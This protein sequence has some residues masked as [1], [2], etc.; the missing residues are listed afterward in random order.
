MPTATHHK[1]ASND[2]PTPGV[3]P[4]TV[5]SRRG[6]PGSGSGGKGSNCFKSC[7]V[8]VT[9]SMAR[10]WVEFVS[11]FASADRGTAL[12]MRSSTLSDV[13]LAA[14]H[15]SGAF[16]GRHHDRDRAALVG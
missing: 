2:L 4:S 16:V 12:P 13:V 5:T 8:N 14:S 11:G 10:L 9:D 7:Q 1:S 15:P 3:P 6:M